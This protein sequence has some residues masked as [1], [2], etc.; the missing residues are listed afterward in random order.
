MANKTVTPAYITYTPAGG[1]EQTI[2]FHSVVSE[3]HSASS[4]VTGF[5]VQSGFVISNNTIRENRKIN[6]V[7]LIT[8]TLIK[9]GKTS[10]EYSSKN[11]NTIFSALESLVN[12]GQTCEVLTNLGDYS[13]VVFTNFSTTQAAGMTDCME[14]T[15]SGEEVQIASTVT[16]TAPQ[17][18]SFTLLSPEDS[19]AR[20][21]SFKV[22]GIDVCECSSVWEAEANLGQDWIVKDVNS[23]GVPVSTTMTSNGQCPVTG[24]W[25][26]TTHTSDTSLFTG[27]A[28]ESEEG[29]LTSFSKKV[30]AGMPALGNC[31]VDAA[32]NV[33]VGAATDLVDTAMG[34]LED[35]IYGAKASI[36]NLS[37]N[38]YAQQMLSAGTSCLVKGATEAIKVFPGLESGSLPSSG[39]IVES[40][41]AWGKDKISPI[42]G[43]TTTRVTETVANGTAGETT[44]I[45]KIVCCA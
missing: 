10:Y 42:I 6:I 4:K 17:V 24:D 43:S 5:P 1:T 35:S 26:Y 23:A 27:I 14:F 31:F 39:E 3:A 38:K 12:S 8:N 19:F 36:N 22:A 16:A 41:I 20:I 9:G 34:A 15:L 30:V 21:A 44:T 2:R 32:E 11:T 29:L 18:L 33:V 37:S 28:E 40:A 13:P 25:S 45:T 7:G